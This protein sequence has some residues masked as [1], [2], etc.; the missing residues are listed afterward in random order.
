MDNNGKLD[1]LDALD[2]LDKLDKI[3]RFWKV[4]LVQNVLI[5]QSFQKRGGESIFRLA[6]ALL[7]ILHE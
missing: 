4:Q 2:L 7:F 5:V 3:Q 1:F 6:S